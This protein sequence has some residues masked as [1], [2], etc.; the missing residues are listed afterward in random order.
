MSL[1]AKR[2]LHLGVFSAGVGNHI[3]GW[4]LP[5]ANRD[6]E[7]FG[8]F[9]QLAAT[10]E[11]GLFDF[12][13]VADNVSS[14]PGDHPSVITR[15]EPLTL[16]SALSVTTT[17][18]G[19]IG[20]A[21][22]TYSEPYNL[23]RMFASLDHIS[24]GR[25]GWNIVTSSHPDGALNFG[26]EAPLDHDLRYKKASEFVK[27]VKGL[28]DSWEDGARV[29][30]VASGEY[31]AV[32]K[33][34]RLNHKGE[35]YSVRGPL[36]ITR[37]PQGYPVLVQAGSS[38]SGQALA[39]ETAE[40]MFTVQHDLSAAKKFYASVKQQVAAAGRRP[41]DCKIL[42]GIFPIV[43][44][45][46]EEAK[47][48]MDELMSFVDDT[49]A[50]GLLSARLGHDMSVFPLDGPFPKLP[51]SQEIQTFSAAFEAM[52][53]MPGTTLRDVYNV[54]AVARGYLVACG[55]ANT[56]ADTMQEWLDGGAA[57]GF[58]VFPAVVPSYLDE[59][60][61]LVIPELQRRGIFRT[62]YT[63]TTLREHLGLERPVNSH[64]P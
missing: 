36:N 21:A 57:D 61:D 43:G 39:A 18:I 12:F 23:A 22:T 51:K 47:R 19:L 25:A 50:M 31:M 20:T 33:M 27:I 41:A 1:H 45:T 53:R 63:G 60:V 37:P 40:L 58:M 54:F 62:A 26:M 44:R 4:R 2:Q 38:T 9:R 8:V 28:W 13:F 14:A 11:R 34:H 59:F 6:G 5:G 10:A 49:S 32:E 29:A 7:D 30:D 3:A 52:G 24:K 35:F 42:P 15:L 17:S 46:E 56:V 48:K 55:T 64:V 16:L